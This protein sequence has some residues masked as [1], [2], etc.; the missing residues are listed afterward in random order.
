MFGL[1]RFKVKCEITKTKEQKEL[2]KWQKIFDEQQKY[3]INYTY[4]SGVFSDKCPNCKTK[5][6]KTFS[7]KHSG[8]LHEILTCK[9]C[10]YQFAVKFQ[11]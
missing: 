1:E 11:Y 3:G 5:L 2:K 8:K 10:S 6:D 4:I 7:L 9:K